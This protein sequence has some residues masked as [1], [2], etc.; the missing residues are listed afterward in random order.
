MKTQN[1]RG[2]T[3]VELVIVIA[4]IAIL[5]AVLIPTFTSIIDKAEASRGLQ[6]LVNKQKEDLIESVLGDDEQANPDGAPD[7][8]SLTSEVEA[9]GIKFISTL[10]KSSFI[11]EETD[12]FEITFDILI[13][14]DS[15]GRMPEYMVGKK[16]EVNLFMEICTDTDRASCSIKRTFDALFVTAPLYRQSRGTLKYALNNLETYAREVSDTDQ[17][18]SDQTKNEIQVSLVPREVLSSEASSIA[19]QNIT[20]LFR[21]T[22]TKNTDENG[23]PTGTHTVTFSLPD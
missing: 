15:I 17:L 19:F 5:A 14:E 22:I 18:F 23:T 7:D 20:V 21:Y 10:E 13:D 6:Q 16:F 3:I 12:E 2:F 1:K 8:T 9:N 4:V 11:L